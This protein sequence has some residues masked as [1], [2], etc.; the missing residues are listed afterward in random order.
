MIDK[1]KDILTGNLFPALDAD[2]PRAAQARFRLRGHVLGQRLAGLEDRQQAQRPRACRCTRKA[3]CRSIRGRRGRTGAATAAPSCVSSGI[4]TATSSTTTPILRGGRGDDD[5][6]MGWQNQHNFHNFIRNTFTRHL[7]AKYPAAFRVV[8]LGTRQG[9][10]LQRRR[11]RRQDRRRRHRH[12]ERAH[13]HD[14]DR[15]RAQ[16][17]GYSSR[18]ARR[19]TSGTTPAT[20]RRGNCRRRGIIAREAFLYRLTDQ[21][22]TSETRLAASDGKVTLKSREGHA[23]RSVPAAGAAA[24]AA[25]SGAKARS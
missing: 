3:T 8:A 22:R 4:P 15:R 21:G 18:G 16:T 20:R 24:E 5:G 12:A 9:S 23:V 2:A 1:R 6:F 17:A 13:R 25:S 7:P 10:R 11:E 14:V 19:S